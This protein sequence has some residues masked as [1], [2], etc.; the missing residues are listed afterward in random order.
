M[1]VDGFTDIGCITAH[2]D[3][4]ADFADHIA[5]VGSDDTATDDVA[6]FSI[7]NQLSETIV[8]TVGNRTAGSSPWEVGFGDFAAGGFGR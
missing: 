4:Q 3:G 6:G 1:W 8:A 5:A 7:K 2:F